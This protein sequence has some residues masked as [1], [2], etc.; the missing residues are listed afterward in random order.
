M[1]EFESELK[2]ESKSSSLCFPHHLFTN[3]VLIIIITYIIFIECLLCVWLCCR[4][5]TC[6]AGNTI[7]TALERGTLLFHSPDEDSKEQLHL[8]RSCA[9]LSA[10][11]GIGIQAVCALDH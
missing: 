7:R 5:F 8:L 2:S 6:T 11:S 1:L 9:V 3:H 10:G 4:H